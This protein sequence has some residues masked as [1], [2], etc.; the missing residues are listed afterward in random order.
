MQVVGYLCVL[1]LLTGGALPA[2]RILCSAVIPPIGATLLPRVDGLPQ[3]AV[4]PRIHGF[5]PIGGAAL[6]SMGW[7]GVD[8]NCWPLYHL[9]W[10][11]GPNAGFVPSWD[12]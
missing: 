4:L 5:A 6:R 7:H 1:P 10:D 2:T 11:R 3:I 12:L 8:D 9:Y